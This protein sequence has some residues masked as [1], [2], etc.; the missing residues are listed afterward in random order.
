MYRVL[1]D[2]DGTFMFVE[3][4][5]D[6]E[7]SFLGFKDSVS[8]KSKDLKDLELKLENLAEAFNLPTLYLEK[9]NNDD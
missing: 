9:E 1:K 3:A 6:E 7:G 8:L 4:T 5:Y 2:T